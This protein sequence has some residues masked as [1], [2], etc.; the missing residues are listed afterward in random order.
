M[1]LIADIPVL[2]DIWRCRKAPARLSDLRAKAGEA[3][4]IVPWI[5]RAEFRRG[6]AVLKVEPEVVERFLAAFPQRE[7]TPAVEARYAEAWAA[8]RAAGKT[9]A[10][11]DLWVAACAL[12]AGL[13]LLTR[14]DPCGA[15]PGLEVIPYALL[16]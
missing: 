15:I 9:P 5:V 11:P 3:S 14:A 7:H 10:Y 4:L 2:I 6:A 13:P 12:E 16:S 8:L 1:E